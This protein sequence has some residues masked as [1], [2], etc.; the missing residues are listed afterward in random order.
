M[1]HAAFKRVLLNIQKYGAL[2][3]M[4]TCTAFTTAFSVCSFSYADTLDYSYRIPLNDTSS[5]RLVYTEDPALDIFR[6]SMGV[7]YEIDPLSSSDDTGGPFHT[8]A[9]L[10]AGLVNLPWMTGSRMYSRSTRTDLEQS[11]LLY[12]TQVGIGFSEQY[13]I[14]ERTKM[15]FGVKTDGFLRLAYNLYDLMPSVA[16]LSSGSPVQEVFAN[17]F[18]GMSYSTIQNRISADVS[19]LTGEY[20]Y[21]LSYTTALTDFIYNESSSGVSFSKQEDFTISLYYDW[22][23]YDY[24][25]GVAA[26]GI[27]GRIDLTRNSSVFSVEGGYR[28]DGT[29]EF[30]IYGTI[31]IDGFIKEEPNSLRNDTRKIPGRFEN[32]VPASKIAREID[33][34][35]IEEAEAVAWDKTLLNNKG[36]S[37]EEIGAV[38]KANHI[39]EMYDFSRVIGIDYTDMRT[40][41]EYIAHGG[42]CR[43]AANTIANILVNNGYQAKIVYSK[44]AVGTPHAF[45]VTKDNEGDYYIF[46]YEDIYEVSGSESL[47]QTAGAYSKSLVLLLLDPQTHRIT[48]LIETPDADYLNRIAGI[49]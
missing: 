9:R 15:R 32:D 6:D 18:S 28:M 47:E 26:E 24:R 11:L 14:S 43:D 49:R 5:L 31:A 30:G 37:I 13:R 41:E 22:A 12:G 17:H 29:F 39:S 33:K 25:N 46:D 2:R 48:D 20:E 8:D 34:K 44:Q 27:R 1:I 7:F 19:F 4:L 23:S 35:F 38:L 42:I 10:F 45:V 21:G 3:L 16:A 36:L 40:P